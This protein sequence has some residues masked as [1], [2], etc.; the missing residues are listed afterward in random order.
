MARTFTSF[1]DLK[2]TL[3]TLG[4]EDM[5]PA[6]SLT[7][8]LAADIL[9]HDPVNRKIRAGNLTK[10]RRDIEGGFW[11]AHKSSPL[12]FLPSRRLADGQ[13]RCR[14]VVDSG[15]PIVV[16]VCTVSDTLGVDEGAGRTLVDHLQLSCELDEATAN[17]ASVVTKALCHVPSASNRDYL[18]FFK[19]H[20]AFITECATKPQTWLAEQASHVAAIFKPAILATLR[21]RAIHEKEEPAELVDQLL[22]DA[23]NGGATAPDGS[24]RRALAKQYFDAM[25]GAFEHKKAKRADML[26]WLLAALKFERDG[27]MKNIVTARLGDKKKRHAKRVSGTVALEAA[28]RLQQPNLGTVS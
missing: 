3:A 5:L 22:F 1:D 19:A 17:L 9:T 26:T 20:E 7:P 23:I 18:V 12:R 25:L 11:D 27:Q 2:T 21:A 15:M 24:P 13:H 8:E 4:P 10:L 16:S 28:H 6:V 14:A